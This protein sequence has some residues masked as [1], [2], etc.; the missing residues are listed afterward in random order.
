MKIRGIVPPMVTP[1][2]A[3]EAIDE[4]AFG[5]EVEYL[6]EAAGVHGLAVGGS[7][8]E[9]QTLSTAELRRI[10]GIALE[11]ADGRVP[12]IA[13]IIVDSTRQAVEKAQALSDLDVRRLASHPG[14]LSV[15]SD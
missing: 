4:A 11:R 10:V 15:S 5:A 1:F 2:D 12:V 9:G 13:G 14:A 3:T 8:G 7:T 6:I